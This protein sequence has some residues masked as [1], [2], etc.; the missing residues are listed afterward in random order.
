VF[1]DLAVEIHEALLTEFS[2]S[3]LADPFSGGPEIEL[4]PVLQE[5]N[6]LGRPVVIVLR[7]PQAPAE[8]VPLLQERFPFLTF[9]FLSG[10]ELPDAS[11]CPETL[12]RRVEPRLVAGREATAMT[13][14]QTA[15]SLLQP[16]E[17]GP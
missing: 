6:R 13:E 16:G 11:V 9:V 7:L 5:L 4:L 10:R 14:Y 17:S 3:L 2:A 15:R 1:E 12:L 8:L